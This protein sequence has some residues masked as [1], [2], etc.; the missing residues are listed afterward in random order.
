MSRRVRTAMCLAAIAGVLALSGAAGGEAPE[1]VRT[2]ILIGGHG[3]D[4]PAFDTFW[5]GVEGVETE[6]WKD[7]PYTAFDSIDAFKH[8]VIVMYNLTSGMTDAQKQNFRKLMS[9]GI[10][11]TAN[12]LPA[13]DK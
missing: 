1:K 8:D 5:G 11:W 10:R 4:R 12:R 7:A 2:L 13:A 3:F 6:V 9:R